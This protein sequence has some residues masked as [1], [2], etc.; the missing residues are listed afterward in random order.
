MIES[1]FNKDLEERI[2]LYINGQLDQDQVDELWSEL[3]QDEYYLDYTKSVANI[4]AIIEQNRKAETVA[5]VRK[6]RQYASYGVAAAIAIIIGVIGVMDFSA[7]NQI[8]GVQPL[9]VLDYGGIRGPED[10][11]AASDNEIIKEAIQ[12][13][14]D[15]E[16]DEAVGLLEEELIRID[17]PTLVAEM[18]LTLGSIQYNFGNYAASLQNFLRVVEQEG[19]SDLTLEKGYWYLG[20]TYFQLDQ[21]AEA[22]QA[23]QSA[24]ELN[25]AYSRVSKSYLDAFSEAK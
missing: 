14:N 17:S 6:L 9:E 5:P 3:I 19:I 24:Y 20:N 8:P 2:D 10:D 21:L 18:S 16:V 13:A 22:E 4:K 1:N 25:G 11:L 15:G 12:L 7:N 23:F